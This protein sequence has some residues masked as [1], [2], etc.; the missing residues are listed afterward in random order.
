MASSDA[1][2]GAGAGPSGAGAG[3]SGGHDA[4]SAEGAIRAELR[5]LLAKQGM[6]AALHRPTAT[7]R[8]KER[9]AVEQAL[10]A[11]P[12]ARGCVESLSTQN[13]RTLV[14]EYSS[15]RTQAEREVSRSSPCS[16]QNAR[17]PRGFLACTHTGAHPPT[18]PPTQS[19]DS[20]HHAG[21]PSL[22]ARR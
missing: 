5:A 3:P 22:P 9:P 7:S 15:A 13:A 19:T 16:W 2:G 18:H 1:S 20:S 10:L 21:A 6:T 14:E 11:D 17:A 4:S 12:C 8:R